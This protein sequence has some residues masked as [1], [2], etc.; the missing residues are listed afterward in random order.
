MNLGILA[1]SDDDV[2][3]TK[4]VSTDPKTVGEGDAI[5]V[6]HIQLKESQIIG[7]KQYRDG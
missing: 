1:V 3:E 4:V 5:C 6:Q 7:L 2:P